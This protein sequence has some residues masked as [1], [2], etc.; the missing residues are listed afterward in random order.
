M[1]CWLTHI[2]LSTAYAP[3]NA[4][5]S[6]R[7]TYYMRSVAEAVYEKLEDQFGADAIHGVGYF[8]DE[9]QEFTRLSGKLEQRCDESVLVD[10]LDNAFLDVWGAITQEKMYD[11]ELHA[12]TRVYDECVDTVIPIGER[13]G[14]VFII[15]RDAE[16]QYAAI[17]EELEAVVTQHKSGGGLESQ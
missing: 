3:A 15:D 10:I 13:E 4:Y 1:I 12:T 9:T 6:K 16:Y 14:I 17:V 2:S 8:N 5:H 11:S 7:I